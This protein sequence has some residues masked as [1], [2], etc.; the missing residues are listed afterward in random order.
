MDSLV[1][2]LL[3]Q[4]ALHREREQVLARAA[5]AGDRGARDALVGESLRLVALRARSLGL[6]DDALDEA[7]QSGTLGLIAAVERFDPDRGC[8][9]ATYAW[10]WITAAIR[11]PACV[12]SPT[13]AL[14]ATSDPVA[15]PPEDLGPAL[16]HLPLRLAQVIRLRYRL[17]EPAGPPRTRKEVATRLGLT[18]GQVRADEARAMTHLRH[19][20]ARVGHRA[21]RAGADPL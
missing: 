12:E 17:G 11:V 16:A 3:A 21:P 14:D 5:R 20:L 1:R 2:R 19:R 8:R 15:D 4:P 18:V 7:V 10:P 13:D 6:R 9:L